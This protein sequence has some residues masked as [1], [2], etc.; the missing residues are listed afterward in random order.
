MISGLFLISNDIF[1]EI[2]SDQKIIENNEVEKSAVFSPFVKVNDDNK[3]VK[4]DAFKAINYDSEIKELK[5]SSEEDLKM[6]F[7]YD[8]ENGKIFK[9]VFSGK[10]INIAVTGLDSRLGEKVG[11]ADA[12]H[13]ISLFPEKG[14]AEIFSIPRDTW[15]DCG[16]PDTSN[17][18]KIS[19][20]RS[21]I[22]KKE[23]LS[24]L[25]KIAGLD[26]IHFHIEMSFSQA[27]GV[28]DALEFKNS[29]NTLQLLR[30]RKGFRG[31]DWQRVYNQG[32]LI[33]RILDKYLNT[34]SSAFSKIIT[35]SILS[36][37]DT[38][39]TKEKAQLIIEKMYQSGFRG[40][41]GQ[42]TVMVKPDTKFNFK[43]I[44]LFN[45]DVIAEYSE[46]NESHSNNN[47]DSLIEYKLT[48]AIARAK[49]YKE[50]PQLLIN[51]LKIY[52]K[53]R[54]WLQFE[55]KEKKNYFRERISDL[56]LNAYLKK[57]D[58]D[59]VAQ[60]ENFLEK[61]RKMLGLNDFESGFGELIIEN[62]FRN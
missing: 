21:K 8:N 49:A 37:V 25:A 27:I 38:D 28:L 15:A 5:V 48:Y 17:F 43:E 9:K 3:T 13:V 30:R 47:L 7:K 52:F 22:G 40:N 10:R 61:E 11:N 57:G 1:S 23:Y 33:K 35:N 62:P 46:N 54:S 60:I 20:V 34:G 55:S 19:L 36:I 50:K 31:G 26:K 2:E 6:P 14:T 39:I 29:K 56:L 45:E 51:E 4:S 16:Q 41:D 42:I 24:E 32:F 18:N 44:D 58:F 59:K 53:Q 12:N